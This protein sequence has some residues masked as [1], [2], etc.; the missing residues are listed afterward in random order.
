[1]PR[2]ARACRVARADPGAIDVVRTYVPATHLSTTTLKHAQA[3]AAIN[4]GVKLN[5]FNELFRPPAV[6]DRKSQ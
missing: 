6:L 2:R 3:D 4:T 5:A 1:M